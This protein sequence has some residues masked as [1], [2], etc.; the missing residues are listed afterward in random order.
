MRK[1]R[2]LNPCENTPIHW[3]WPRWRLRRRSAGQRSPAPALSSPARR[4]LARRLSVSQ[5]L[6]APNHSSL[7]QRGPVR[8]SLAS[9]PNI[10][11]DERPR[12]DTPI[13]GVLITTCRTAHARIGPT[14]NRPCFDERGGRLLC[15]CLGA[16]AR[17]YSSTSGALG[18][19]AAP[20]V[21]RVIKETYR[22]SEPIKSRRLTKTDI[23]LFEQLYRD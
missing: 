21:C 23:L 17:C 18:Q 1:I 14:K 8:A 22:K 2:R 9:R 11:N 5:A 16:Y 3:P 13:G 7:A 12:S 20:G 19:C 15:I 4:E 10:T 6:P